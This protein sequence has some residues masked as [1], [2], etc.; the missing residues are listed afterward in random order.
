MEYPEI[1]DIAKGNV[2]PISIQIQLM[3]EEM[4]QQ[5]LKQQR[6]KSIYVASHKI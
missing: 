1:S 2:I 5:Y 3:K 6:L 4:E